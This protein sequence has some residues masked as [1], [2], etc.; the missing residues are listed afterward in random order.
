HGMSCRPVFRPSGAFDKLFERLAPSFGVIGRRDAAYLQW[1][2]AAN[3][4]CEQQLVAIERRGELVGW[5][6]L[7]MSA[8]GCLL[9]DYLLPLE[10][11]A[12][13]QALA[14]LIGYVHSQGAARLTLRCNLQGP[15]RWHFL[16]MGFLPGR[17]R[18]TW[19]VLVGD[20][21]LPPLMDPAAWHLTGGDLNPEA[22]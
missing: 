16:T 19:Q 21:F 1:R 18:E 15:Y 5:A 10:L 17:T 4:V 13:R 3:P 20:L 2:Y 11:D 6:A 12:G 9:L 22:S 14:T 8:R 7:E